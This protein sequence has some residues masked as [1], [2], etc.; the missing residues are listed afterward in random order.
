LSATPRMEA[1]VTALLDATNATWRAAAVYIVGLREDETG[2][3]WLERALK[4]TNGWVRAAAIPGL[5]RTAKDRAALELRLG[6]LMADSD[7]RVAERTMAGLLE[8]ETRAAAGMDY[9]FEYFE[10][11]QI[12]S[13]HSYRS[14]SGEQRPLTT[15]PGKP[16]FLEQVRQRASA[17][18][19]EEAALPALLL[20]QYGDFTGLD[21]LLPALVGDHQGQTELGNV[22]LI[23]VA[24]SHDPK[25]LPYLKKMTATAKDSSDF[26]RLLQALKGISGPEARELRLEINRRMR[27][28]G[29]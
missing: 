7:K 1:V 3:P 21:H 28:S 9:S 25:Y 8:P 12:H 17:S 10:F 27:Q 14:R 24:L 5:A 22:L 4:D 6:P 13:W 18:D 2:L 16:A 11:E 23:G 19:P 26:T 20:A 15:L 29:E